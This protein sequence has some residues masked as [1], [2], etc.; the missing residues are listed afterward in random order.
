MKCWGG[1]EKCWFTSYSKNKKPLFSMEEK[2]KKETC[3]VKKKNHSHSSTSHKY[4]SHIDLLQCLVI[5]TFALFKLSKF[6]FNALE[7][8]FLIYDY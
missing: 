5:L 7:D 2:D 4:H 8:K 3:F 1:F 6:G